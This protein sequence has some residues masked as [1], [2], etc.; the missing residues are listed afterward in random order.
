MAPQLRGFFIV[1]SNYQQHRRI[2]LEIGANRRMFGRF[3][4]Q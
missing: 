1:V 2:K 3:F 4:T